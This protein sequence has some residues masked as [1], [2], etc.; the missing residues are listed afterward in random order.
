DSYTI[1]FYGPKGEPYLPMTTDVSFPKGTARKELQIKLPRGVLVRGKVTEEAGSKPVAGARVDFWCKGLKVPAGAR[2]R[3]HTETA[4]DGTF[5][6]VLLP[7]QWYALVN[8]PAS[9]Y[10]WHKLEADKLTDQ[11]IQAPAVVKK[12]ELLGKKVEKGYFYPD[13]WTALDLK[14]SA[15]PQ[16]VAVKLRQ[17]IVK[18]QVVGLDG[19]PA[20][21]AKVVLQRMLFPEQHAAAR[22]QHNAP[23]WVDVTAEAGLGAAFVDD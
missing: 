13:Q 22:G 20:T 3:A 12:L 2:L 8:A 17:M 23:V 7:G 6:A 15:E 11:P 10:L 5:H 9:V 16:Q 1:R 18:G 19:K 21:K 4:A 14:P